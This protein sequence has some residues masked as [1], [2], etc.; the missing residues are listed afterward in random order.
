METALKGAEEILVNLRKIPVTT[1]AYVEQQSYNSFF[2]R[3]S[4]K[5]FHE[6]YHIKLLYSFYKIK[7]TVKSFTLVH[8]LLVG[9]ILTIQRNAT[10]IIRLQAHGQMQLFFVNLNQLIHP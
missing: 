1:L 10:N 2:A 3:F 5:D 6:N 8:V 9:P 7:M 4:S